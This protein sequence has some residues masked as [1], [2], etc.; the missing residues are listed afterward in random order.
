MMTE[1]L[2]FTPPR[3]KHPARLFALVV[4][5]TAALS[6][7]DRALSSTGSSRSSTGRVSASHPAHN[8]A[9]T[10]VHS[11]IRRLPELDPPA[12]AVRTVAHLQPQRET[13]TQPLVL[14][15]SPPTDAPTEPVPAPTPVVTN[16]N[17]TFV[18]DLATALR[19]GGARSL[20]IQIARQRTLQ[21]EI[22][23]RKAQAALL[24]DLW[25]GVGWNRHNGRIQ[26]TEGDVI[27]AGRNS[28]FLGGGGGLN[29]APVAGGSGGPS[30]LVVNLSLADAHF[31][32]LVAN[33]LLEAAG[34]AE[35]RDINFTMLEIATAY[36]NLL[37]ARSLLANA[38]EAVDASK[39]MARQTKDF[40]AAGK[41]AESETLRA[42]TEQ[43]LWQRRAEDAQRLVARQTAGLARMLRLSFRVVLI[44]AEDQ[45]FPVDLIDDSMSLEQLVAIG[46]S[47]RPELIQHDALVQ[48]RMQQ[49]RQENFR[50]FLPNVQLGASGGSF[51]GGRSSNFDDQGSRSDVDV[52]AVWEL[53]NMGVGNLQLQRQRCSQLEQAE[54]A[55]ELL[56][57]QIVTEIVEATTDVTNYRKQIEIARQA[58]RTANKSYDANVQRIRDAVGLPIEML[59]AIRARTDAQNAFSRSISDYNRAQYRLMFTL[60]EPPGTAGQ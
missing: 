39:D 47:S 51:G 8:V 58:T 44:P 59:Q 5:A 41:V 19:L 54:L 3:A 57:D 27:E 17:E 60:G 50:P 14:L 46:L 1:L 31:Q 30:R 32:P 43:L 23:W 22:E 2:H 20:Q 48:A 40:F 10:G 42:M 4:L 18:V 16:D 26:A 11:K 52:L 6:L 29:G 49:V 38:R 9:P 37:E 33:Q 36:F 34:A 24:P 15:Q 56:Q 55:V 45:L 53:R 7:P 21:A 25:M 28:L 12:T 35:Q 13:A